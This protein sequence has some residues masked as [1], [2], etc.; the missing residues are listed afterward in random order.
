MIPFDADYKRAFV[1][2]GTLGEVRGSIIVHLNW[3]L[4]H[5][6]SP[7]RKLIVAKYIKLWSALGGTQADLTTVVEN[8]P[9]RLCGQGRLKLP[10]ISEG[11]V[12][13]H[14]FSGSCEQGPLN[15]GYTHVLGGGHGGGTVTSRN[16]DPCV[17]DVQLP[18]AY[19][20][21][22]TAKGSGEAGAF[23][24]HLCQHLY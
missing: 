23:A 15:V 11:V 16:M 8:A 13:P 10:A 14:P 22:T 18:K 12:V 7:T 5:K 19:D 20:V 9:L 4:A 1:R 3:V 6:Q 24:E 21:P 17:D 2:W